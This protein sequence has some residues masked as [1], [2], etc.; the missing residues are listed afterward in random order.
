MKINAIVLLSVLLLL[1]NNFIWALSGNR[2]QPQYFFVGTYTDSGSEGIYSFSIDPLTGKLTDHGLAARSNNPSFLALTANK[3]FLLAAAETKGENGNNS[4]YIESFAVSGNNF[5]L[6][7]VSKVA[8]GGAH[9]C[10][11]SVNKDYNVLVAN[12][13][14]GNV[15]LFRLDK[16]GR[17]TEALDIQQH[18]G[19]GL[20][21]GRQDK[22]H[23]HSAFFE[24]GTNRIFVPDLGIDQVS[25]Y[26][27]NKGGTR[28]L[29][30]PFP[31]IFMTPGSGPR[32]LIF[33]PVL[34]I[35]YVVNEM[36]STVSAVAL[37][38]DGSFKTLETV[39]T[40]PVSNKMAN[41][42]ADIHIS[43]DGRF[44]YVSN[45]GLNSVTIFSVDPVNGKIVQIAQEPT[46]GET[47]RNFTLSPDDDFLLV[48]NQTSEDIVA[49]RRDPATGK[50]HFTDQIKA[51]KP[52]C[53]LFV[54]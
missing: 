40:L 4:G 19:V 6:T 32:H 45:R 27:I 44:L 20:D 2:N 3:D 46:R 7:P 30:T 42:C 5:H 49:F 17:L 11:V 33:H 39:S 24:P 21:K 10:Y 18:Y 51:F 43:K 38:S 22:P 16:S 52:V 8:S 34:K 1:T 35:V 48:A 15:A 14:G 25:V 36:A 53:L 9:P 13:F 54:K 29:G 28:L 41:T 37:N 31:A 12:Y 50:L 26:Q 47:P 23:V